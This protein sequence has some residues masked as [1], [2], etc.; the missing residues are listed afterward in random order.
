MKKK[1]AIALSVLLLM[2]S[3]ALS[4]AALAEAVLIAPIGQEDAAQTATETKA[5]AAPGASWRVSGDSVS[6]TVSGEPGLRMYVDATI[7][8]DD[9]VYAGETVTFTGAKAGESYGLEVDYYDLQPGVSAYRTTIKV[10]EAE[11]VTPPAEEVTPPAEEVTPPV[12]EV[13]PPVEEVTPPVEEVTPP[14]EEV[15]PPVEE[16]TPPAE[17]VTPPVEEVT[18]PAEE[19]TPP[20]EEVTP[21]VEEVTPPVEEVT[22]PAEEVT[23][24]AEEVTPPAEEENP[25]QDA[26]KQFALSAFVQDGVISAQI[27]GA[28]QREVEIELLLGGARVEM[29]S[30]IGDG[31]VAFSKQGDGAYTVRAAYVTPADGVT[32]IEKGVEISHT[33]SEGAAPGEKVPTVTRIG[34][35]VSSGDDWIEVKVTDADAWPLYVAVGND[36]KEVARGESVRFTGLSAGEYDIEADYVDPVSGVTPFRSSVS[37]T[38][39]SAGAIVFSAAG[40]ENRIEVIVSQASTLPVSVTVKKDG[41]AVAVKTIPGG[42]GR[43]D[44]EGL[45]AGEYSVLVAYDPAQDGISGKEQTGVIVTESAPAPTVKE[46]AFSAV[47][48][49]QKIDV[50]VTQASNLPVRVRV[51]MNGAE[52]AAKTITAGVGTVSFDSLAAGTYS[53]RANYDPAQD[54]IAAKEQKDVTVAAEA[55]GIV[56]TG[57]VAGENVLTVTGTAQPGADIAL[58]TT[59]AADTATI[60]RADAQGKFT[61]KITLKAGTYTQVT[62]VCVSDNTK[63]A[64]L[65]GSYVVTAPAAK[66]AL[67]VDPITNKT[68]TVLARTTPGVKVNLRVKAYKYGQTVVADANGLLRYSFPQTYPKGTEVTFT[69]FYG[70]DNAQSY[71][72]I[73]TIVKEETYTQLKYGDSGSKVKELTK[74]L[75]E[76]GYLDDDTSRYS[77]AVRDA[78]KLF[79]EINGL[80]V[81]G[82]AGHKTQEKLFSV[83]ALPYGEQGEYP[84]LVRGDKGL[85]SIYKL[86]RRLKDLGYYTI[87]VDGIYGA[88]TERS[89]RHFQRINGLT[90]TGKADSATQKLL[91]SS[92]AKPANSASAENYKVLSRSSSY[93]PAVVPLQ[94]RL[95]ALGYPA[96]SADGYFG[97]RTYRA[98]REFQR[99][100][101]LK[102]TGIADEE[103]QR[104]L[105]SSSA[106][107][108]S[109]SSSSGSSSSSSSSVAYRLLYWGCEGEDVKALQKALLAKGYTQ[110]RV[111]D[112]IY[113]QWTYDAVR[114]FQKDRGLAVDGI[115]GKATQSALYG[116]K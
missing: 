8:W 40:G 68:Q 2:A 48:G 89:V 9:E 27:S 7:G 54:G 108:A 79:Q 14:V 72:Q 91:Y 55:I 92:S 74:R 105:Y 62:A 11:E 20:V 106:I 101:G 116:V 36:F 95:V 58:V 51:M 114:A 78:V 81:D 42:V 30:V 24:P 23:P 82:V 66:P 84:T 19:V 67:S 80:D 56:L 63:T 86:Q 39:A 83:G 71:V 4:A 46:I 59:P 96:G 99:R 49:V 35:A 29:R 85:A 87:A 97:S 69:V 43:A 70:E 33:G 31:M 47:G 107:A 103:T 21:P 37:I 73:E 17:E 109:G 44:F 15:T 64:T 3:G 102:A 12:E 34:A 6:V 18:P 13:T 115:A 5:V 65:S 111:A 93:H 61:A 28:S 77:S 90:K 53:V 38:K 60:V 52:V 26:V 32:A 112:G 110:V 1:L 98:V 16:V 45:A 94:R 41:A 10:P 113:G 25:A 50:T 104:V 88:G 76:L 22:P 75:E 100:N 57:A